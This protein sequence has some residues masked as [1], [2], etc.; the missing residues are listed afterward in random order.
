MLCRFQ[1]HF[2]KNQ[3]CIIVCMM[4]VLGGTCSGVCDMLRGTC[5]GVCD[6][7]RGRCPGVCDVLRG[8][9]PGVCVGHSTSLWSWFFPSIFPQL[10]VSH[11]G[12]QALLTLS[13]VSQSKVNT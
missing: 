10:Q 3:L 6:V 2:K 12:Q 8:M 1:N 9:C 7:L 5:P 11:S 13:K 4:P